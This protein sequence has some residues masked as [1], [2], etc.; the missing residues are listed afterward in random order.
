MALPP[1]LTGRANRGVFDLTT[2]KRAAVSRSRMA[3]PLK[4]TERIASKCM[5]DTISHRAR[6]SRS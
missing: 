3:P 5:N 4:Q 6:L 1:L 2:K